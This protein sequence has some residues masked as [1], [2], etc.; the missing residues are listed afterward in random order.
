MAE[1]TIKVSEEVYAILESLRK[2]N[3]SLEMLLLRLLPIK[4]TKITKDM[5]FGKW[6]GSDEEI[7]SIFTIINS[8]WKDWSNSLQT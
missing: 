6:I 1:K 8:A 3:E 2:E 5:F 4:D 7:D